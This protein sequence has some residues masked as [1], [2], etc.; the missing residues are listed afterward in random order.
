MGKEE[1]LCEQLWV[2][3]R[4]W[5]WMEEEEPGQRYHSEEQDKEEYVRA[6]WVYDSRT[7][8]LW[9]PSLSKHF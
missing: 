3:W 8:T 2:A 7:V 5:E 9:S 1:M 4:Q 6:E